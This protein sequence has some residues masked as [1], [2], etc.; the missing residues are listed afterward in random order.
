LALSAFAAPVVAA[1]PS[2]AGV[3]A[4]RPAVTDHAGP[5]AGRLLV[6]GLQGTIGGTIG[7]DGALYVP[8][9]TPGRITRVDPR[10]GDTST[11]ADGLPPRV[12]GLGGV[13][14]VTFVGGTAYALV[15]LVSSDVGGSNVDGI[16]RIDGPHHWTVIADIGAWSIA[17][18]PKTEFQVPSGLQYALEPVAG[19][20]L[21]SDGHHN[22]VLRVTSAGH[23]GKLIALD[24]VVPTGLAVSGNKVFT[25]EVG[26]VPYKPRDGRVVV[27]NR[28]GGGLHDVASGYSVMVDVEFAANHGL[29]AVSQGDSPGPDV[30]PAD[31]AE[32]NT[33]R[34]LRVN[35]DGSLDVLVR[36]L[37]LPT[38]VHFVG[39]D[40]LVVTLTGEVWRINGVAGGHADRCYG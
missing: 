29:Y 20:F 39:D 33:G 31:P 23:V 5:S 25:A 12:V 16:Y 26:P 38:S 9:A 6:S 18:P 7:P 21:V 19:G 30:Q 17:H 28:R 36:R 32:P 22:R 27:F 14:D 3:T 11:F 8:E 24:D 15:T 35:C 13:M 4:T 37:N 40:A 34:L 1:A 2:A 10:T